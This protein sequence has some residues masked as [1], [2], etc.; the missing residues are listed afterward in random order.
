MDETDKWSYAYEFEIK[1]KKSENTIGF[2]IT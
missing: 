2:V 1:G